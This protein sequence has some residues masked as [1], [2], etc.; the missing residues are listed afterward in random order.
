MD[1]FTSNST[2]DTEIQPDLSKIIPG[3]NHYLEVKSFK[4]WVVEAQVPKQLISLTVQS[5]EYFM[6]ECNV[7]TY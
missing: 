6:S 4:T 2:T 1:D 3:T 5:L 7:N